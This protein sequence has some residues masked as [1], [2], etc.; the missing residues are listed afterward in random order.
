MPPTWDIAVFTPRTPAPLS[1][2]DLR[3]AL[4]SPVGQPPLR[5]Q[6]RGKTRPVILLDDL[7]RPTPSDRVL[8]LILDLL[9][10]AGIAREQVTLVIGGGTH[11]AATYEQ[12][13]RKVGPVGRACKVVIHDQRKNLVR[14][15]STSFGSPV[16]VRREVAASDL[17]IGIGGV[18]PQHSVGFGGGSKLLLGALGRKSIISLHYGHGSVAGTYDIDNDFRR[19]LDEM[20]DLLSFR[21]LVTLHVDDNRQIV[22]IAFG[23]F[24]RYYRQAVSFSRTAYAAPMP[25]D[26]DVVIAN[27]YPMDV[28]LT[29]VRSKGMA[30][31]FRARPGASRVLIAACTEGLGHHG[32]FPFLDG[33]R[34]E[35][36]IHQ[37]RRL[38]VVRVSSVPGKIVRRLQRRSSKTMHGTRPVPQIGAINRSVHLYPTDTAAA[39][40][41]PPEI[42]GMSVKDSWTDVLNA[43]HNEQAGKTRI[44]VAVYPCSPLHCLN[45]DGVQMI[46]HLAQATLV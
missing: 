44:R 30:P 17:L 33:P 28:S 40:L 3:A 8:P 26:A 36:Q 24:R 41:L 43:V 13:L 35:K 6:A 39:F 32:L 45:L 42:P 18:Y 12:A 1:D 31:L 15:G 11:R 37:L 38:S 19:D 25:G 27:A 7:T 16:I 10:E 22:R 29:F 4:E 23:D 9:S 20:A 21:S 2:R 14:V 46:D 34:W 5:E